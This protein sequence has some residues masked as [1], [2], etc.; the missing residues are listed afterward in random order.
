M[1]KVLAWK[2][3][4]VREAKLEVDVVL[5][6]LHILIQGPETLNEA[7]EMYVFAVLTFIDMRSSAWRM[8][9]Q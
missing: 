3:H 6:D 7:A 4:L 1:L 5:R 2:G 8:D 9:G